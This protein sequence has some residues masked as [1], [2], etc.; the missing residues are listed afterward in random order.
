MPHRDL[1][2]QRATTIPQIL[3]D[4][5]G[6]LLADQERRAVGVAAHVVRADTQIR[7]LESLD[8]VHVEALV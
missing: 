2:I 8:S 4:Q 7:T 6:R 3:R 1:H 5:H